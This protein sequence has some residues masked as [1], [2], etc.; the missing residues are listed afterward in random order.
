MNRCTPI[1]KCCTLHFRFPPLWGNLFLFC[2]PF[3]YTHSLELISPNWRQLGNA[4]AEFQPAFL[5]PLSRREYE[6]SSSLCKG[7]PPLC[8]NGFLR[9]PPSP[10]SMR[11]FSCGGRER[12][13]NPPPAPPLRWPSRLNDLLAQILWAN[14]STVYRRR[15]RGSGRSLDFASCLFIIHERLKEAETNVNECRRVRFYF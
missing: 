4:N 12:C 8:A 11:R 7:V 14:K 6:A 15:G 13:E 2:P 5:P 9:F 10:A 1:N 3:M